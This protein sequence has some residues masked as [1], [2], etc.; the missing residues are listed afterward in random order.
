MFG[1]HFL[2]GGCGGD[3]PPTSIARGAMTLYGAPLGGGLGETPSK[4]IFW[5][6]CLVKYCNFVVN[7][8]S[9]SLGC[10][11]DGR[12]YVRAFFP[13]RKPYFMYDE[14]VFQRFMSVNIVL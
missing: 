12:S 13:R 10:I 8:D 3:C 2:T 11:Y 14:I 9:S 7:L 4:I 6:N 5:E 1:S